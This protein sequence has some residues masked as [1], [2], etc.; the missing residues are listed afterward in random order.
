MDFR[1]LY[2]RLSAIVFL[3]LVLA[4]TPQKKKQNNHSDTPVSGFDVPEG[5][6]LLF[7]GKTLNGWEITNFGTEGPITVSEGKIVINMGDGVSGITWTGEFPKMNYEVNLEACKTAGNDFFCG[8]TFPVNDEFCSLI[9]GGWGGP[10]V[11]LSC[12][13]GLDASEN[14]TKTLKRF[15]KDVWYQIK[16]QVTDEQI[17]AWVDADKLVDFSYRGRKL[18]TRPEVDLSKPFGICT[19]I[20]TSEIRNIWMREL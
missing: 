10:V 6:Q 5:G 17:T 11:G 8:M 16:L 13:D 14:E 20:T 4:C 1:K 18:N 2:P 19:W 9:L 15:D 12:I 7:D 3:V